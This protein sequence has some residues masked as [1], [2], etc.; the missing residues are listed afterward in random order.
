MSLPCWEVSV[1][2]LLPS[3]G[4]FKLLSMVFEEVLHSHTRPSLPPA[5]HKL[6]FLSAH[7]P[8]L[9]FPSPSLFKT[10]CILSEAFTT[11]PGIV[12][13]STLLDDNE[14]CCVVI[15]RLQLFLS[16]NCEP[17]QGRYHTSVDLQSRPSTWCLGCSRVAKLCID[18]MNQW[19]SETICL[20][21]LQIFLMFI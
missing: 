16:W 14:W 17:C 15:L 2:L 7:V 4:K 3:G 9:L 19:V 20:S 13:S 10:K 21:C 12:G 6:P 8:F 11:V 18:G 1:Y 5:C